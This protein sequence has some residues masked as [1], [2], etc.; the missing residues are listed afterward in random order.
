MLARREGAAGNAIDEDLDSR[1]AVRRRQPHVVGRALVAERRR[2]RPVHGEMRGIGERQPKLRQRRR[3]F[4]AAVRHGAQI[5]DGQ[6][7]L[8]VAG[9]GRRRDRRRIRRPHRRGRHGVG[10][11]HRVGL[12][13]GRP[14]LGQPAAIGAR[15]RQ[16]DALRQAEREV[17]PHLVDA[18]QRRGARLRHLAGVARR[19]EV[20]EAQAGVIVA[21]PDDPVEVDFGRSISASRPSRP[22]RRLDVE[23]RGGLR[24]DRHASSRIVLPQRS[25]RGNRRAARPRPASWS[26]AFGDRARRSPLRASRMVRIWSVA[27]G[28]RRAAVENVDVAVEGEAFL[29]EHPQ[30][31]PAARMRLADH[32]RALSVSIA[33]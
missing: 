22:R 12:L 13:D 8:A 16:E 18:L 11:K 31:R 10:G 6:V 29:L 3:P 15:L 2:H 20:A 5:G 17:G 24:V 26:A 27:R 32:A 4:V 19:G 7:A 1:L 21:R 30:R 25:R 28:H 9:V 33:T 23:Q 14:E